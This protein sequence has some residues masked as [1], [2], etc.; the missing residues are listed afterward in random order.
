M[1][2]PD[3]EGRILLVDD[4]PAILRTFRYCLEDEGY[5]VATASSGDQAQALVQGQVFDL[6]FLDLR[7]GADDGLE[8]LTRLRM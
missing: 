2:T 6:C 3:K 5:T 4:E 8:V 7:L 1:Q